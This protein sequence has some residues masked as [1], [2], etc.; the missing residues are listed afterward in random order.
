[1]TPTRSLL[2]VPG[3]RP[4]RFDKA[5]N[6]GAHQVILDL[7][8]AVAPAEKAKARVAI[9]SWIRC[10]EAVL[11]IN[12]ADT[13]W[14]RD[15]LEL[16]QRAGI[17]KVMIPKAEPEALR[18]AAVALGREVEL[19][20]LIETISG[21]L[22]LREI[23]REPRVCRLAFGNLD[24]ALD[25]GM[26]ELDRELDPAR[27]QLAWESR[28]ARLPPPIDGV[29]PTLDD[30]PGLVTR[31]LRAKAL[32]FGGKLCIHPRQV[33]SVNEGFLPGAEEIAWARRVID[34]VEA[35]GDA[36]ISL[37]GKMVDRPVVER[38]RGYLRDRDPN[39]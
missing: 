38:A 9:A 13:E 21:L 15:D 30:P 24:F 8:D 11:R 18:A 26:T 28:F 20:A 17:A 33:R 2:F 7:E 4:D 34:A 3:D 32:G 25:A 23:C 39:A 31:V 37:D 16:A 1:M 5:A 12:G 6:S 36:A 14:F 35:A 29:F 22:R 19:V 27:V 10:R